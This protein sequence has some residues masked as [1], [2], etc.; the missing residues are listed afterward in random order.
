MEESRRQLDKHICST[1]AVLG[2]GIG[3]QESCG[4]RQLSQG[5]DEF[6]LEWVKDIRAKDRTD[7]LISFRK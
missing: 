4:C 5:V 1:K 7:G 6:F 3:I 2:L